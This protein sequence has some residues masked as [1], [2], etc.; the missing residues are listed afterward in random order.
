MK[1]Y[2]WVDILQSLALVAIAFVQFMQAKNL[3]SIAKFVW[4]RPWDALGRNKGDTK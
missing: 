4:R 1:P 3:H 2:H